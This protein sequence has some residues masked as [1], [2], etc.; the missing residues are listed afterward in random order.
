[1]LVRLARV[2]GGIVRGA[3]GVGASDPMGDGGGAD[4]EK[5]RKLFRMGMPQEHVEMK[6]EREGADPALFDVR[7][8]ASGSLF[9][10]EPA[11]GR[12]GAADAATRAAWHAAIDARRKLEVEELEKAR[13][14]ER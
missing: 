2:F 12:R 6:M 4:F 14:K 11:F 3:V 10:A 8:C 9:L 5:Y 7:L 1:M 13:E